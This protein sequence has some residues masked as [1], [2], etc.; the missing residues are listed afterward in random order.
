M[1]VDEV[2]YCIR[3]GNRLSEEYRSGKLR[4]VCPVCNWIFFPDPKVAVAVLAEK[5]GQV[6]LV[7]RANEPERGRWTLPA[8]FLDAGEDPVL[9]AERE[10][11]EETGLHVKV[12]TLLDVV[13]KLE[14][15]QGA[16]III[17]YKAK[18]VSGEIVPG[19]DADMVA[20][21]S[22]NDLPQLA[23]DSTRQIIDLIP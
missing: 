3:C 18:I 12:E 19:D 9:A 8:G 22:P 16:H 11:L 7:R 14:H 1:I 17:F 20:F 6:L 2:N 13:S 10:C 4:P 15:P 23:F 5:E 21:F